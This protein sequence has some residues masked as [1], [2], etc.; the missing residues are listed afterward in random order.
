[1]TERPDPV[2]VPLALKATAK[3]G[4]RACSLRRAANRPT[5]PGCHVSLAVT[6]TAGPVAAHQ[7]AVGLGAR[8]GQHLLLHQLAFLVQPVEGLGDALGLAGVVGGEQPAAQARIADAAAG[9]DARADQERQV[10]RVDGLADARH[11]GQRGQPGILLLA[12]HLQPLDDEG[13]VDAGQRDDVADG[14]ERHQVERRQ[15]VGAGDAVALAQDAR[16]PEPRS[17]RPRRRRKDG[18]GPRDRRRG[19]G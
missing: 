19:W 18:P 12:Q 9:V 16:R 13:A 6:T 2:P 1:M 5:M 7:L 4:R 8:L 11:A 14:G 3:A 17:G 15:Q 10:E